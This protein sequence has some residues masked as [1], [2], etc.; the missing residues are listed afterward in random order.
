[1]FTPAS[2]ITSKLK[3]A[4]YSGN[5]YQSCDTLPYYNFI[6][7]AVSG[8]LTH[9]AI[10]GR[11][12]PQQLTEAWQNI[13]EEYTNLSK[14]ETAIHRL[15][16]LKQLYEI[17]GK[18]VII[19]AIVQA[20]NRGVGELKPAFIQELRKQGFGYK[21]TADTMGGDL[22]RTISKAKSLK[23]Q[24]D[25]LQSELKTDESKPAT[26]QDYYDQL[27]VMSVF[28]KYDLDPRKITVSEFISKLAVYKQANTPKNGITGED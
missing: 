28:Y 27:N 20:L 9:L 3:Q 22:K 23:I 11:V 19:E 16:T 21:Y 15:E 24:L 7:I 13:Q 1:M 18:L 8:N 25:Q 4:L 5:H 14:D 10:S 26:E 2:K 17:N 12:S 6:K